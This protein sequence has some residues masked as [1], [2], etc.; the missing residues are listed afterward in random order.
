MPLLI[1]SVQ[2]TQ[3]EKPISLRVSFGEKKMEKIRQFCEDYLT[4]LIKDYDR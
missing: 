4:V 3:K 1:H 2:Y